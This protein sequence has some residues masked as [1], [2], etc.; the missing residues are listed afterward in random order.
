MIRLDINLLPPRKKEKLKFLIKFIFTKE[1]L[2]LII[3]F[4]AIAAIALIWSWLVLQQSLADL[5]SASALVNRDYTS[6]NKDIRVINTLIK[7]INKSSAEYQAINPKLIELINNLPTNIKLVSLSLNRQT[8]TLE[9]QGIAS[10]R[11]DLL[12]YQTTLKK[13]SWLEEVSTPVSKLFQK[14]DITFEFKTK[15]KDFVPVKL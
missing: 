11:E 15:I 14:T 10:T 3:F 5:A 4:C 8:Q 9:L 12:N 13:I 2:E 1:I 7:N 6:Y